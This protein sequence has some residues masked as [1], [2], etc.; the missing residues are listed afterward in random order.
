MEELLPSIFPPL[1]LFARAFGFCST[2]PFFS[3]PRIPRR[4]RL[5]LALFVSMPFF[6]GGADS[7]ALAAPLEE[8]T[9]FLASV[10]LLES[11]FGAVMGFASELL[12]Q[13][14]Q[15]FGALM[16]RR[17]NLASAQS[18][19]PLSM[20]KSSPLSTISTVSAALVFLLFNGHHLFITAFAASLKSL[21][22][23]SLSF[24]SMAG[25]GA[26]ILL[27]AGG[28]CF[29]GAF[30]FALPC[31]F[32]LFI[33]ELV[34][35]IVAKVFPSLLVFGK[36]P[37]LRMMLSLFFFLLTLAAAVNWVL[38]ITDLASQPSTFAR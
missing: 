7:L 20:E 3:S 22:L 13:A 10:I 33:A 24:S 29:A 19:S 9:L 31:L 37:S 26:E 4:L 25:S 32:L 1:L 35:V 17:S 5:G 23:A 2:A 12:F 8:G 18:A 38:P 15:V 11:L 28:T 30:R 16:D 21:P 34:L 27:R 6:G 14:Y 36:D